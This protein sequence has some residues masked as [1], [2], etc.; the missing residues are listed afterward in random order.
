[1]Q[2]IKGDCPRIKVGEL[3]RMTKVNCLMDNIK[4]LALVLDYVLREGMGELPI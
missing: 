3:S 2:L 1:M 4:K